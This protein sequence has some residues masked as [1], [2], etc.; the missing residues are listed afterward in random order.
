MTGVNHCR[1]RGPVS[2]TAETAPPITVRRSIARAHFARQRTL[3][4]KLCSSFRRFHHDL[5]TG[6]GAAAIGRRVSHHEQNQ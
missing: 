6:A 5:G 3:F 4:K 2:K 1:D